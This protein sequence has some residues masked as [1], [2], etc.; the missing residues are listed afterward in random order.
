MVEVPYITIDIQGH[1]FNMVIDSG[2]EA[3]MITKEALDIIS[4]EPCTQEIILTAM[5]G[6]K[7]PMSTVTIPVTVNGKEISENFIVH[8]SDNFCQFKTRYGLVAHGILGSSF[9]KRVD[10]F[11][12][13]K[14]HSVTF[15]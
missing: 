13:F 4:Y 7:V 14:N 10:S 6:E 3:S 15:H 5:N 8:Y 11:I 1:P 9:L 12:N 2:A